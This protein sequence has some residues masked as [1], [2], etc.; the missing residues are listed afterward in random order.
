MRVTIRSVKDL[1][2]NSGIPEEIV[3]RHIDAFTNFTF[4]VAKRERKYCRKK[5]LQWVHSG[6][7]VKPRLTDVLSLKLENEDEQEIY[8][9]L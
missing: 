8:D 4:A 5:I 7:I 9:V 2:L 1:A 6:E 3:L